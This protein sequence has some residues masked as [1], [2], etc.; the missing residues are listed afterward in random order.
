MLGSA[1][2]FG[3]AVPA[4][5]A[6]QVVSGHVRDG[7]TGEYI[8]DA[9]VTLIREDSVAGLS[10]ATG[11]DGYFQLPLPRPDTVRVRFAALGYAS[12]TSEPLAVATREIVEVEVR[13]AVDALELPPLVVEARR[14]DRRRRALR[15]F[16]RRYDSGQRTGFGVFFTREDL[17][18]VSF[19]SHEF[20]KVP[21]LRYRYGPEGMTLGS[22]MC[23]ATVYLNGLPVGSSAVDEIWPE[24]LEA[25]EIYRRESEIPIDLKRPGS[26]TVV[27]MW[28]RI[29][30]ESSGGRYWL[31]MGLLG[32]LVGGFVVLVAGN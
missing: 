11:P 31:R 23:G 2:L 4:A 15:E 28:T 7:S 10:V 19:L 8:A 14:Q 5:G 13:L 25:I 30:T 20:V 9:T 21:G 18:D 12:Y 1:L 24:D 17:E 29:G 26:C 27:A 16:Y 32:A 3:W 22:R 6:G